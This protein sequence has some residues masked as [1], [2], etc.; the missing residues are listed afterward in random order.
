MTLEQDLAR[1]DLSINAMALSE[2]GSIIDP[3][4]GQAD[5][6]ARLLQGAA[7]P[8]HAAARQHLRPALIAQMRVRRDR[9]VVFDLTG[10]YVEAFYNPETDTILNPM[11]E[12]CPSWSLFDEGKNHADFTAIASAILPTDGGGQ[13]PFWMLGARTL[14][15]QTCMKLIKK[16]QATNQALASQLMMAD[17]EE[18]HELLKH[19]IAEP[20]TAPVA[21]RMA[22]SVR[23]VLNT[24]VTAGVLA[25]GFT[26][27]AP[28][29]SA[30][31]TSNKQARHLPSV[32]FAATLQGAIHS[33]AITGRVSA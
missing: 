2:D 7:V 21:A 6:Q 19:T 20:L 26:L 27:T 3:F 4:N 23:A 22:E 24:A 9:A 5:L 10:A 11:D 30:V 17:L 32:S 29:A 15:V 14:F 8:D 1:R 28:K 25:S 33:V 13:D 31:S 16:G 18:V 12:R